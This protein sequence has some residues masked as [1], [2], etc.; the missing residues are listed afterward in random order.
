MAN[1]R[2]LE[3]ICRYAE[4]NKRN[5]LFEMML[6]YGVDDRLMNLGYGL[7]DEWAGA[8]AVELY[9]TYFSEDRVYKYTQNE[10]EMERYGNELFIPDRDEV[11]EI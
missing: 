6:G 1:L 8:C 5:D 7:L 9:E 4:V 10:R 2:S 3:M 11:Y